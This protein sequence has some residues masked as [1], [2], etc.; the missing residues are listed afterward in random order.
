M[1][2]AVLACTEE[3][4]LVILT[5]IILIS[6]KA[7]V[8]TREF[9]RLTIGSLLDDLHAVKWEASRSLNVPCHLGDTH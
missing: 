4:I 3:R 7:G 2:I 5:D 8:V 6:V 9:D 1:A